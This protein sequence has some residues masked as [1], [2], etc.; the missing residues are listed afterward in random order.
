MYEAHD[1]LRLCSRISLGQL[2]ARLSFSEQ[3]I[4]SLLCHTMCCII[5]HLVAKKDDARKRHKRL[6]FLFIEYAT[7]PK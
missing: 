4:L 3:D 1:R 5:L 7:W 6:F 2:L